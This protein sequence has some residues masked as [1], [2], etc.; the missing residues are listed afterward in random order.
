MELQWDGTGPE[1][2]GDAR[3]MVITLAGEGSRGHIH[4]SDMD[5]VLQWTGSHPD[6]LRS[7]IRLIPRHEF[8]IIGR[9]QSALETHPRSQVETERLA[10][11]VCS[12]IIGQEIDVTAASRGLS[13]EAVA[14]ILRYSK[15]EDVRTNSE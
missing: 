5:R 14:L 3:R 10:N 9:T 2:I 6:E 4:F 15:A 7:V 1:F 11:R 12:L 13:C 8:L